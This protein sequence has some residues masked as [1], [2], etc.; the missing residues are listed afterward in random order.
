MSRTRSAAATLVASV[1]LALAG[2]GTA[3]ASPPPVT[4][5]EPTVLSSGFFQ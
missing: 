4:L 1:L 3:L 5:L 2:A